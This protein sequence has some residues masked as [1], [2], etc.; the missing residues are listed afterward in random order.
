MDFKIKDLNCPVPVDDKSRILLA[1]G[2]G[3]AHMHKLLDK[4]ILPKLMSKQLAYNHDSAV[5]NIENTKLAFTT[6]SYVVDP[7]FFPGGDIGSLSVYGTVNDLAMSGAKA[8]YI[9]VAFI[10]EEGFAIADLERVLASMQAAAS[11]VGVEIVTGDTKVVERGKGHGLYINTAGIG[12]VKHN[13]IIR[14]DQIQIGDLIIVNGDIGRHGIAVM[15]HRE[16]LQFETTI[17]S[18]SASVN[19]IIERLLAENITIHCLRDVTRGGLATTLNE[20]AASSNTHIKLNEVAIPVQEEVGNACELLGLDVLHVA[21]EGRFVAFIPESEA[22]RAL[23]IMRSCQHGSTAQVIGVVA[24]DN[25][26]NGVTMTNCIGVSRIVDK[27]SGEQ[28]PRIC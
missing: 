26:F 27:L 15:A 28:L 13:V 2:S 10:L 9:S 7:L 23:E 5:L 18:D 8:L 22:V 12:V 24:K 4:V 3:G 21:C 11:L 1:H 25:S 14:P 20:L 16:G 6:D 17:T 19:H